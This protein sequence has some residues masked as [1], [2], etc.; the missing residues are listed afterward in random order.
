M[1]LLLLLL[2]QD[3]VLDPEAERKSFDVAPG[4]EVNLYAAEPWI[5]NPVQMVFDARG[6]L[7]VV[8]MQSFP[9]IEAGKLPSDTLVVLEDRDG[10]GRADR[11]TVFADD[12]HVPTGVELGDGG[13]YVAN[14]P[15]LLFLRD[16]DGDGKADVRKIVFSGFG[17]E[18]NHHAISTF[19]W[20][21][22]G[23]L[24]MHS[25]I[26]LHSQV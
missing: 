12:L 4:Y 25:G 6:R 17:S 15:D 21:P 18:D 24:Y 22:G 20:G 14:Q 9:Q 23:W 11:H 26:F 16:T 5:A 8:C 7:W 10:D 13:V 19:N 2:L 3:G 1:T